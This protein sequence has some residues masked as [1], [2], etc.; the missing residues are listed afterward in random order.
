MWLAWL[1]YLYGNVLPLEGATLASQMITFMRWL[2][3]IPAAISGWYLALMLGI[4]LLALAERTCPAENRVSGIC[5]AWWFG[6]IEKLIVYIGVAVAA[7]LVVIFPTLMA[8]SHR[9]LVAGSIFLLGALVAGYLAWE[10]SAWGEFLAAVAAG[11]SA[12]LW[13]ESSWGHWLKP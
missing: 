7:F 8:P 10:L 13:Q 12:V 9:Y 2:G 6:Y 3:L 5:T 11:L 1:Y 4:F